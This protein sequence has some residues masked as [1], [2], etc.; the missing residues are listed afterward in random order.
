MA[1]RRQTFTTRR[2]R[3]Y[4]HATACPVLE[5]RQATLAKN[6]KALGQKKFRWTGAIQRFILLRTIWREQLVLAAQSNSP[7]ILHVQIGKE[8]N[9]EL[10]LPYAV[11]A[12]IAGAGIV[13]GL[14]FAFSNF[15]MRA[16]AELTDEQGMYAMQQINEKIINPIFL[17]FFF[18][19]PLFCLL[20][21]IYSVLNLGESQ[22][23]LLLA[24]AV[25]YIIGPFGIT[26]CFNVPMN[27]KLAATE[28]AI[29]ADVWAK[30]QVNWQRWNH[31]RT[32]IGLVSIVLLGL[33]IAL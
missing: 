15:V 2:L 5:I 33:G 31:V 17:L 27:N 9:L 32:Y 12:A 21:A 4:R 24:G 22:N 18:G 6:S 28:S 25:G 3:L 7:V 29:G 1:R 26:V 8:M 23:V 11:V 13:T 19:T 10:I 20:I 30:Y 14:L 16:L